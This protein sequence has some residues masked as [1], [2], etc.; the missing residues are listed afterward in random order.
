MKD[1][2]KSAFTAAATSTR[3]FDEYGE[4]GEYWIETNREKIDAF[5]A[6]FAAAIRDQA[7]DEAAR[8]TES[9][10]IVDD[11]DLAA[12]SDMDRILGNRAAAIRALKGK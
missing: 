1:E 5:C 7:L 8:I 10:C 6:A 9:L 2:L 4:S 11:D 12:Q 3:A